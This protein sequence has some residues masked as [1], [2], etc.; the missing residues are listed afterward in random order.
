MRR[1]GGLGKHP[2][3]AAERAD[4]LAAIDPDWNPRESGWTVDWQRHHVALTQLLAAGARLADIVPG[5]TRQ[6]EDIG[7]WL[8]TQQRD[9]G[10]L[11]DEQRKR[12]GKLGVKAAVRARTAAATRSP[13]AKYTGSSRNRA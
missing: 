10:R 11:N 12:L 7:R 3:R 13:C 4:A 8:A 2:V 1:P 6:G 5:V 9:F